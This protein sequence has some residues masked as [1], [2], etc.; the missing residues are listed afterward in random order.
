M[1]ARVG[2]CPFPQSQGRE[3]VRRSLLVI[4][5]VS[6]KEV[7]IQTGPPRLPEPGQT[8]SLGVGR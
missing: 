1:L 3:D 5:H 7:S 6:S 8:E 4:D 2:S